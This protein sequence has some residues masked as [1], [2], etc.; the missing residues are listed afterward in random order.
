MDVSVVLGWDKTMVEA[1]SKMYGRYR[2][3][4]VMMMA[5]GMTMMLRPAQSP[6]RAAGRQSPRMKLGK[7]S[8]DEAR[9]WD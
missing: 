2:D 5:G 1:I 7:T 8:P 6:R 3:L 9:P 4:R